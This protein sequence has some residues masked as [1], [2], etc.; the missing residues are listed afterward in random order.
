MI[1]I[2][3]IHEELHEGGGNKAL[4]FSPYLEKLVENPFQTSSPGNVDIRLSMDL[5]DNIFF[6][7]DTAVL[8]GIIVNGLVSNS[9]KHA[10]PDRRSGEIQIRLYEEERV[11]KET[12]NWVR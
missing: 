8:L 9:L 11:R 4:Y 5:K 6:D 12:Q 7:V 10:F 1:S 3:L 2:A